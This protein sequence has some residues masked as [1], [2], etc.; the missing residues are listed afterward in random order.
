MMLPPI[1]FGKRGSRKKNLFPKLGMGNSIYTNASPFSSIYKNRVS[2]KSSVREKIRTGEESSPKKLEFKENSRP[3][4]SSEL[5]K[6]KVRHYSKN[7]LD[8][9]KSTEVNHSL[10][11][12][13]NDLL[14]GQPPILKKKL[15][16][17]LKDMELING[18]S[19]TT[20]RSIDI[21]N[22]QDVRSYHQVKRSVEDHLLKF[23]HMI[24]DIRK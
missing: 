3:L 6:K 9:R 13:E 17:R 5:E 19:M 22:Q 1:I 20:T 18:H 21:N 23:Q 10:L 7:R 12:I 16:S 4:N 15:T 11:I 24:P 14:K 2:L 8:L